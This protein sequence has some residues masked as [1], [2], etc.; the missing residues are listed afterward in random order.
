MARRAT[1]VILPLL[2]LVSVGCADIDFPGAFERETVRGSGTVATE[3]RNVAGFQEVELAGTGELSIE[4]GTTESLTIQAEDNL[5]PRIRTEVEGGRLL[6]GTE[7]GVSIRP[8]KP[9]LYQLVVKELA[10]LKL[11]G[12]GKAQSRAL[13]CEDLMLQLPG[14]GSI[15]ID[16]LGAATLRAS[17]SGSGNIQVAGS[18]PAQEVRI[19]GSGDYDGKYLESKTA[20]VSISG[21]GESAV[22]VSDRLSAHISGSGNVEYYGSPE[23]SKRIS[24]SGSVSNRGAKP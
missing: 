17:I 1:W 23:V 12:S 11:S 4:Q 3:H 10:G 19:S 22:W 16:K 21:S 7:R 18:A 13:R 24:G 14:S 9:I 6:I 5:L 15:E 2:A 8:T 20:E